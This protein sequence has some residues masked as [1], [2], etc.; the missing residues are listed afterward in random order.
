ML[1]II[2]IALV[3]FGAIAVVLGAVRA[4]IGPHMVDRVIA[5]DMLTVAGVAFAALAARASGS[6]AFLDV[7]LGIALMGFVATIAFSRLIE[8][9]PENPEDREERP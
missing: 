4:V 2:D 5:L 3:L 7:A 9:L 6:G 1:E 8:R